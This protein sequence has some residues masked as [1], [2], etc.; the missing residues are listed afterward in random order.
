MKE[1]NGF[2]L[3][4]L[5]AVIVILAIIALITVPVVINIINSTKKGAAEDSMYGLLDAIKLEWVN[6]QNNFIQENSLVVI[7]C[8]GTTCTVGDIVVPAEAYLSL[9]SGTKPTAGR[10][11]IEN[12]EVSATGVKF[13]EYTCKTENGKAVCEK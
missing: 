2:T 5:L 11:V 6:Q 13:G 1:N 7:E 4:E 12:G 10:F 9:V 3:I 8:G